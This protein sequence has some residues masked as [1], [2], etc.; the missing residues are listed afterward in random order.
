MLEVES[1]A[2][3][4]V[5]EWLGT[6]SKAGEY[7][8]IS[9]ATVSRNQ[10]RFQALSNELKDAGCL[11][12]LAMERAIHQKW[13]FDQGCDLRLHAFRWTNCLTR[14]Q[15][16]A[17]WKLN[18]FTV[19]G[20]KKSVLDLVERRVIDA[21]CVPYPLIASADSSI[22]AFLPLYRSCLQVMTNAESV[23]ASERCLSAGDV[24]DTT[25]LQ[26]LPFVPKEAARCS[27]EIDAVQFASDGTSTMSSQA[28][29]RYWGIPL[30]TLVVPDLCALDYDTSIPYEE[31][32][33]VLKEWE[34]HPRVSALREKVTNS[35]QSTLGES[36][37]SQLVDVIT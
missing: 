25:V 26:Q 17:G 18:P 9:Q 13:R 10:A 35:L 22:F 2:I 14:W 7:L 8:W 19:S 15:P 34:G 28:P 29:F 12:L 21:A 3:A 6:G 23:L 31:Y 32:L 36:D 37:V 27:A 30:T 1:L 24:S 33:V 4:D 20:T 16:L 11:D 5:Y